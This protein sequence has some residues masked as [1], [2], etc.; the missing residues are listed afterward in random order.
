MK[1]EP[2]VAPPGL[3]APPLH[4]CSTFA[5]PLGGWG[6]A[7][8]RLQ[9]DRCS[10]GGGKGRP[11]LRAQSTGRN[12]V[13]VRDLPLTAAR[14]AEILDAVKA[15]L[16]RGT[17][18]TVITEAL[19]LPNSTVDSWKADPEVAEAVRVARDLGYDW[20]AHEC[21][22]IIDDTSGDVIYDNDGNPH[23]NG[24][25]VLRAKARVETR[26]K[27]LARWDPKRYAES[28]RVELDVDVKSTVKHVVDSRSLTDAGRA[29]LRQLLA[30]A[31]A[32]GL[33]PP[34][35]SPDDHDVIEGQIVNYH[36]GIAGAEGESEGSADEDA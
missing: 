7:N 9:A 34:P 25:N 19:Q 14:R 18:L 5:P 23:P 21:L 26:L 24:A 22:A 8:Q 3:Y 28:R 36:S 1:G 29:A 33:L 10:L 16:A 27:L 31:Q 13:G 35:A 20:I 11:S 2:S 17:P 6:G 32:Q 4:L 12:I 15:G 30:E